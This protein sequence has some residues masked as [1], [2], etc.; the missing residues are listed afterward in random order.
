MASATWS[1][2]DDTRLRKL[3]KSGKG[4][5]EIAREMQRT[6]SAVRV[7]AVKLGIAFARQENA[8]QRGRLMAY[9]KGR[10]S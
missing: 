9:A 7:R 10:Q 1:T 6:K 3:A 5:A 8:M 2:E 4:M